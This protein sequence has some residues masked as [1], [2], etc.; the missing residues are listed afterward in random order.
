M[1]RLKKETKKDK[2][3]TVVFLGAVSRGA[4]L[5]LKIQKEWFYIIKQTLSML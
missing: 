1:V 3:Q 2:D 4:Q 5:F